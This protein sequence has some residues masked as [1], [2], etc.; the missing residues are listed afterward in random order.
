MRRLSPI[1]LATSR[2]KTTNFNVALAPQARISALAWLDE[3]SSASW[4]YVQGDNFHFASA[5]DASA[6][7]AWLMAQAVR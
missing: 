4:V 7:R 5:L 6:F 3:R 2:T 1:E